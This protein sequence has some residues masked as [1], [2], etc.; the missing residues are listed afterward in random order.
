MIDDKKKAMLGASET[1]AWTD[2]KK[3][4]KDSQVNIPSED[5]VETAKEW[6]EENEK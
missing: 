6:V 4:E 3:I 5:A 1:E 2:H